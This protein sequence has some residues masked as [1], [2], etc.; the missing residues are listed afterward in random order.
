MFMSN[1][2]QSS[3]KSLIGIG[4]GP[5]NMAIALY[6]HALSEAG[7]A[8]I[9]VQLIESEAAGANWTGQAGYTDGKFLLDTSA[10]KDLSFPGRSGWGPGVDRVLAEHAFTEYLKDRNTFAHWVSDGMP[11]ITHETFGQYVEWVGERI[12]TPIR[13]GTV[14]SVGAHGEKVRVAVDEAEAQRLLVADG[15]VM[16]GPGA[17]KRIVRQ[18][19]DPARI[20]DARTYWTGRA[21]FAALSGGR[22][23][24][25]GSG[26]SAGTIA[27]SVLTANPDTRVEI[28]NKSGLLPQQSAGVRENLLC[29]LPDADWPLR[30]L[31]SRLEF[32]KKTN[33]GVIDAATKQFLDHHDGCV[34][35]AGRVCEVRAEPEG[36]A[37]G[38]T[39]GRWRVYDRVVVAIGFSPAAALRPLL[40]PAADA[41][42]LD[43]LERDEVLDHSLR[44]QDCP[45]NLHIP[46]L[47]GRSQGPGLALLS[48][49]ATMAG[50]V[51]SPYLP[52][53]LLA[54]VGQETT[55]G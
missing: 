20:F 39:D 26:L 36:I 27:K 45:F 44:P 32:I 5:R 2:M 52:V 38:T 50:R 28:I 15:V 3:G 47:A 23:A 22:V 9:D 1:S 33:N 40:D 4:A 54:P 13:R 10:L 51:V 17:A 30:P 49:L 35:M 21:A 19:D 55:N 48:C 18:D 12:S 34:V 24:V 41:G 25:I 14:R 11:P 7:I 37:V 42:W 53:P 29:S 43:A 8:K 31:E 16:S 46:A 6:A